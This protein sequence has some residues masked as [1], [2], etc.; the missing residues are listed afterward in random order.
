[1]GIL[2]FFFFGDGSGAGDDT[3]Q[4]GSALL[5]VYLVD[6]LPVRQTLQ[7]AAAAGFA[8]L[9]KFW[10]P[11]PKIVPPLHLDVSAVSVVWI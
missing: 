11:D 2:F 5:V 3:L 10:L 7:G 1:M 8:T 4:C 9:P 6:P